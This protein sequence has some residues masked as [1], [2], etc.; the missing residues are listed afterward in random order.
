MSTA[1]EGTSANQNQMYNV[2]KNEDERRKAV[3]ISGFLIQ[4][5]YSIPI[6]SNSKQRFRNSDFFRY[7]KHS[8][9]LTETYC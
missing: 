7:F 4:F 2:A 6:A 3:P 8:N 9:N 1:L 5:I